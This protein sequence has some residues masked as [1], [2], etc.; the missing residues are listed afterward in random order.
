MCCFSLLSYNDYRNDS[1]LILGLC[2]S[3]PELDKVES[4]LLIIG[5]ADRTLES[6]GL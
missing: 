1:L 2:F 5:L 6:E 3:L 4:L